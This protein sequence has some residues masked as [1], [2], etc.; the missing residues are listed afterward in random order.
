MQSYY[1]M[2]KQTKKAWNSYLQQQNKN[3]RTCG[4]F[5]I[6]ISYVC[7][8]H[9]RSHIHGNPCKSHSYHSYLECLC[10]C[11]MRVYNSRWEHPNPSNH[12][13]CNGQ[14]SHRRKDSGKCRS[15]RSHRGLPL[16]QYGINSV[17]ELMF[18]S[19]LTKVYQLHRVF[20]V[21]WYAFVG[22]IRTLVEMDEFKTSIKLKCYNV[23][24]QNKNNKN[25][26][27]TSTYLFFYKIAPGLT[28]K[29]MTPSAQRKHTPCYSFRLQ[30]KLTSAHRALLSDVH[31]FIV[32]CRVNV[33]W[34]NN[35]T[36]YSS[37]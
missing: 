29:D 36:R 3:R 20:K 5:N 6:P 24:Y 15:S 31:D 32:V 18:R 19:V 22:Y 4:I 12:C 17:L 1:Q 9:T 11:S 16:K 33:T 10:H 35:G 7:I 27:K 23:S 28:P 37:T 14:L 34:H 21:V 30:T 2:P 8:L 26:R 13:H 25:I